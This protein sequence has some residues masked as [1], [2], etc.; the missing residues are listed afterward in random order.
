MVIGKCSLAL[1]LKL[2][3]YFSFIQS[4]VFHYILGKILKNFLTSDN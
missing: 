2:P 1:S 4:K 3:T